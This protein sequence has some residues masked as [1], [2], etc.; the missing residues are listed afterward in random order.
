MVAERL[1]HTLGPATKK[2]LLPNYVLLRLT[3]AARVVEERSW[4]TFE[5]AEAN[6][7]RSERYDGNPDNHRSF[8]MTASQPALYC[9]S[10]MQSAV[11]RNSFTCSLIIT[12]LLVG[13]WMGGTVTQT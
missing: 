6:M 2:A 12:V 3:A 9:L 7:T 1:F 5:S 4:R 11:D 13:F 8:T 10:R